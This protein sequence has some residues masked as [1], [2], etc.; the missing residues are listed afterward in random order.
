M[1]TTANLLSALKVTVWFNDGDISTESSDAGAVTGYVATGYEWKFGADQDL[2]V[3][4]QVGYTHLFSSERSIDYCRNC[5]SE[6][7]DID[8]GVYANGRSY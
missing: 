2:T 5:Y 8:G 4:A 6:D 1:T 7:I 3:L